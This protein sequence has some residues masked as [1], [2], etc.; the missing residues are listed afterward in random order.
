MS[1]IPTAAPVIGE[2]ERRY[3][4]EALDSGWVSSAGPFV[5]RFEREFAA[6]VGVREAVS[7][8]NGSVALHLVLHALGVK[9]GDEV[10]VPDC[11]FVATAHAVLMCGAVPVFVD[12]D[13]ET[14]CMDPRAVKRAFSPRTRAIIP[15]HLYGHP[16]ELSE[17]SELAQA[18]GVPLIED[19]AQAHGATYAGR[20]V[21]SLG[22]AGCFSFFGN[23]VMTTGEGGMVTTNDPVFAERLRYLKDHG[24]RPE[25]RYYHDELAFNYRITNLQAAL[26]VAQLE[27][28]EGFIARK[29]AIAAR[30][31]ELLADVAG[32]GFQQERAPA[33]N[34][35]WMPCVLTPRP[36]DQVITELRRHDVDSRPVF[37]PMSELPHLSGYP[38]FGVDSDDCPVA[39][40]LREHGLV[41]PCGCNLTEAEQQQVVQALRTV[42]GA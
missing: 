16:A 24:M 3:V 28:I 31:R 1:L 34:I 4:L 37:V 14:L 9:A 30:Y 8:S 7:V 40:E 41:L 39:R 35:Y 5:E 13:P 11:T 38:R 15:V 29:R 18:H 32:L 6:Y 36:A 17:L 27:Q 22:I 33:K 10:I 2:L 12:V 23:K 25:R 21:G 26:G 20:R 19:A 42:L